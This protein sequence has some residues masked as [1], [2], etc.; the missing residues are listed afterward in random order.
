VSGGS[1]TAAYYGLFGRRIFD[2]FE[3]RFLKKN[4][5]KELLEETL[6]SSEAFK[7]LSS[8]FGRSDL[9]AEYYNENL[10]EG[11]TFWN[12]AARGDS[13]ATN[14]NKILILLLCRQNFSARNDL[15]SGFRPIS[16]KNGTIY[17]NPRNQK[18]PNPYF[19]Q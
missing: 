1:F 15:C 4:I 18:C 19:F 8:T 13:P 6:F 12:I 10:F 7:L 17:I 2:D 5:Q 14:F 3:N 9:A 16:G 11:S